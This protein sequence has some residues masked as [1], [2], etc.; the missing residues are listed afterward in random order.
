MT[1]LF[2]EAHS[3]RF[4][5]HLVAAEGISAGQAVLEQQPYAA[6]LYGDQVP[7]RCDW[8]FRTAAVS[9]TLL[10]CTRSKFAHYCSREHQKAAWKAYYRQE[11][12]ALVACAPHAPPATVRLAARVLWRRDRCGL[13]PVLLHGLVVVCIVLHLL[14][15]ASCVRLHA[16]SSLLLLMQLPPRSSA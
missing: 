14:H 16:P 5:R 8:C 6:V 7:L 12:A 4:G 15:I 11:C 13:L 10:R 9:C 2:Q 1:C 3:A